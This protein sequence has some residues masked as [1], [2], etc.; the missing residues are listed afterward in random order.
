MS[1]GDDEYKGIVLCFLRILRGVRDILRARQR[2]FAFFAQ[3][4]SIVVMTR[5]RLLALLIL[6]IGLTIGYFVYT[7]EK[8]PVSDFGFKLGLDLSGGIHLIYIADTSN[9]K[10]GDTG[11]ALESLRDVI[12]RRVNALGVAE[13]VVQVEKSGVGDTIEDRL[14]VELPGVTDL[15]KA[16]AQIGATPLLEFKLRTISSDSAASTTVAY[17]DTGLTGQ[18]LKRA[19]LVFDPTSGK[20]MVSLAFTS[21][22]SKLFEEITRA[23]VGE[24]LAIFLDGTPISEPV[25]QEA[26]TGGSAQIN[27]NF[28]PAEGR[29][30]VRNLNYGALPVPITL[31]STE[32]IGATLGAKA[33]NAGVAAGYGAFILVAIFLLVWYRLPGLVAVVALSLYVFLN[34]AIFKLIPVTLT[35]AGVAGFILSLGMAVDAN[36]LIFERMKEEVRRGKSLYDAIHEGFARAWLSIRDSNLSSIITAAILYY[37]AATNI[38]RGFALVFGIGVLTSMFTAVTVS[39]YLLKAVMIS[40]KSAEILFGSA[41]SR[42][43]KKES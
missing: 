11:G 29:E 2:H 18:Y 43:V 39:R 42:A 8:N 27:G 7:T 24:V 33:V 5:T 21:D 9:L 30:L 12:E 36:V 22:G 28:T 38:V 40:G 41:F 31:A 34:L 35:A 32:T 3:I 16:I 1:D 6:I 19:D 37:F 4:G 14:I 20:P 15:K 10:D 26:I 25:V 23:N 17:K 13:P